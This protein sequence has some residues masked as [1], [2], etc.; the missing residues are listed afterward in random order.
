MSE[1][2][3]RLTHYGFLQIV[4]AKAAEFLQGQLSCNMNDCQDSTPIP[5]VYCTPKGRVISNFM[6]LRLADDRFLMRLRD[7]IADTTAEVLRKY[8]VFSRVTIERP[9]P[10]YIA[11]GRI[12]ENDEAIDEAIEGATAIVRG[13]GYQEVWMP[14][15]LGASL[16]TS[17]KADH[18]RLAML[19]AGKVD[20]GARTSDEFLPNMLGFTRDGSV[21]FKK[22]CYTG[23]EIVARAHYRGAVKRDLY[24]AKGEG[25]AP[26]A[27]TEL[28]A[29]SKTVGVVVDAVK[30]DQGWEGLAVCGEAANNGCARTE[31]QREVSLSP[32]VIS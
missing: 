26:S 7:D 27:G 1:T 31:D 19:R 11:L 18:W 16:A 4:G 30:S 28:Y 22:G 25:Q 3:A 12:I 13:S 14:A 15:E 17:D 20:I 10:A 29:D 6:I 24:H 2:L 5:G 21:H 9:E 8:G 23:Q 32:H